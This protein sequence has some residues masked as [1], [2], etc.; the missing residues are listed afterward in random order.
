MPW[1]LRVEVSGAQAV[2]GEWP[3]IAGGG[4]VDGRPDDSPVSRIR[5]EWRDGK[6]LSALEN[7]IRIIRAYAPGARRAAA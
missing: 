3:L 6:P 2:Y 1:G 5:R 7:A 4:R